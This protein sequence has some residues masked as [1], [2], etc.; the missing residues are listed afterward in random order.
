MGADAIDGRCVNVAGGDAA[1]PSGV[2]NF[3][4]GTDRRAL[5]VSMHKE[6]GQLSTRARSSMAAALIALML[7]LTACGGGDDNDSDDTR[8][9]AP[10]TTE[11]DD[12]AVEDDETT[13]TTLPP[14]E[15]AW[16]DLTAATTVVATL[17]AAPNPDAPELAQ[18]FTGESLSGMQATM[19]D[20][21]AGG[22]ADTSI[23][24][25]R[26]SVTVV[27]DTATVDYCYTSNTTYL[28][29]AGN[30]TGASEATSMRGT[31]QM[32]HVD[33]MWKIAEQTFTPEECPSS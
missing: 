20:L 24:P 27:G 2:T 29:T 33:D 9:D 13:T 14:E 16:A 5:G 6:Y 18:H 21:Q 4:Q 15:Q 28:D 32:Q 3:S 31:A 7:G 17:S 11:S 23:Q 26:Y 22:G 19:R 8:S 12:E 30:P 10:T 1:R 25:H